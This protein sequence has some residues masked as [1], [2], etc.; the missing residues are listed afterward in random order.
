MRINEERFA[1]LDKAERI[2]FSHYEGW[3]VKDDEMT[4]YIDDDSI[5]DIVDDLCSEIDRLQEQLE[6]QK[7]H[8][9]EIIKEYYK[10]KSNYEL[11]GINK[12]IF[13]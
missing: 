5:I 12:D 10:P 2:L 9:E 13:Y 1:V 7:E 11:Y 4:G 6:E 3:N 8:Y